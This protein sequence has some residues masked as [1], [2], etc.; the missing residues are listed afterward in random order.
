MV[1][2]GGPRKETVLLAS[3]IMPAS[4]TSAVTNSL[5]H[6]ARYTAVPQFKGIAFAPTRNNNLQFLVSLTNPGGQPDFLAHFWNVVNHL[7][8]AG[9]RSTFESSLG[10][11]S[12]LL[13]AVRSVNQKVFSLP[14][15]NWV[16]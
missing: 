11:I 5:Y 12:I 16:P 10:L 8:D 3:E 9:E 14:K 1:S 2:G 7:S 6:G 13:G 4:M 15:G